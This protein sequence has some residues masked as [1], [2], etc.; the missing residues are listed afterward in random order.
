MLPVDRGEEHE[1]VA[2]GWFAAVASA[3]VLVAVLDGFGEQRHDARFVAFAVQVDHRVS[4]VE[5]EVAD[6]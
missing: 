5:S 3:Q 4:G 2:A 6:P 1:R